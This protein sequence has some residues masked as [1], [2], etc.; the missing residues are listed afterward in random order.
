MNRGLVHAYY[1]DGK[2]KTTAAAGLALRAYGA[3]YAVLFVQFLKDGRSS[4]VEVLRTRLGIPVLAGTVTKHMT[5]EMT[6]EEKTLTRILLADIW[7]SVLDWTRK[8]AARV[9]DFPQTG[10][11]Q[12]AP[13]SSESGRLL[14]LDEILGAIETGL[15]PEEKLL[16]FL[17]ERPEDLEVVLT[18]RNPSLAVI[19]RTDYR[20]QIVCAGHPYDR[21]I[22]A[23]RGIEF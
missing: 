8:G 5:F 7:T 9:D 6:D 15:F 16:A 13:M 4:E 11:D 2:G 20:S 21:G 10:E 12:K 1:G 17:D 3:G 23:R 18:G 22:I 14:V 19:D